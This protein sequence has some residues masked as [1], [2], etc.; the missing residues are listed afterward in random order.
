MATATLYSDGLVSI[1]SAIA[2]SLTGGALVLQDISSTTL[3]QATLNAPPFNTPDPVTGVMTLN[4]PISSTVSADGTIAKLVFQDVSSSNIFG[5]IAGTFVFTADD[6]TDVLTSASHPFVNDDIVFVDSDGTLP[7]GLSPATPYYVINSNAGVDLQLSATL[8]GSAIDM[9]D[10]GSGT[11]RIYFANCGLRIPAI[12]FN[13]NTIQI[14]FCQF[15][16]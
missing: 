7:A 16:P 2:S 10:T 12:V 3:W 9:T 5:A 1:S 4:T 14:D 8:G 15:T 6:T 13:G 11:H